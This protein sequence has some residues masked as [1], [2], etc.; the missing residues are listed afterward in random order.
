MPDYVHF[1]YSRGYDPN[2]SQLEELYYHYHYDL[3]GYLDDPDFNP[4]MDEVRDYAIF[5]YEFGL[6]D[7]G[8]DPYD[9]TDEDIEAWWEQY[10]ES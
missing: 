1:A 6:A 7:L 2:D 3:K 9:A 8:F 5:L 4:T 10:S